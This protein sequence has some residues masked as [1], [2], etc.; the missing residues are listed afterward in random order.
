M[1]EGENKGYKILNFLK[2]QRQLLMSKNDD[3]NENYSVTRRASITTE[4]QKSDESK[5]TTSAMSEMAQNVCELSGK[6]EMMTQET[7]SQIEEVRDLEKVVEKLEKVP[8]CSNTSDQLS[9]V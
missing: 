7:R 2:E 4:N 1:A 3:V 6:L 8:K 5:V 9:R